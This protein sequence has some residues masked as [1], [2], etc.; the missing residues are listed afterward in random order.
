MTYEDFK[1]YC[2]EECIKADSIKAVMIMCRIPKLR[3]MWKRIP[4]KKRILAWEMEFDEQQKL[5]QADR[6][7]RQNQ[8]RRQSHYID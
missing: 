8:R 6:I 3:E 2:T 1:V 4:K 7:R 5:K